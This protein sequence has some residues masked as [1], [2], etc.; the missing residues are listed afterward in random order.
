[1]ANAS[2]S[3]KSKKLAIVKLGATKQIRVSI[4]TFKGKEMLVVR[5]QYKDDEDEWQFGKNGINLALAR[6]D[7]D[8]LMTIAK[9][10]KGV[11]DGLDDAEEDE[12]EDE[13]PA[14]KKKVVEEDEDDE[15][16]KPKKKK[17]TVKKKAE[18][19]E[20]DEDED[21]KPKKKKKKVEDDDN[22]DEEDEDDDPFGDD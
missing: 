1:M 18:E 2:Q 19:D 15:D 11:A 12:D 7:K 3:G 16:E 20:D 9:A 10:I 5:E 14:K 4:D 21:E 6:M 22:E 17:K 8:K 13:K